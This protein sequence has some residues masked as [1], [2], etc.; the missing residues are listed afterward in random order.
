LKRL[1][2]FTVGACAVVLLGVVA[3]GGGSPGEE[4]AEAINLRI[5]ENAVAEASAWSHQDLESMPTIDPEPLVLPEPGLDLM[6]AR[7]VETYTVDG[8]GTDTVELAGWIAVRHGLPR[9]DGG[10]A[11]TWDTATIDTEFVA[12]D[13]RGHSEIF[14]E[15]RVTLNDHKRSL[16]QVGGKACPVDA[17]WIRQNVFG[18]AEEESR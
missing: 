14:G 10:S 5:I 9:A 18:T 4:V 11:V 6:R 13:L 2:Y 17:D 3:R 1:V 15:V 12:M 7:V 16:G 8:V